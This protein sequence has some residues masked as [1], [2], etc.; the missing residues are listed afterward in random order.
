MK[1]LFRAAAGPRIGFGHVVRCRSLARA[2][3][4][5][6]RVWLRGTAQTQAHAQRAGVDVV[7]GRPLDTDAW[8]READVI[9]LDE[10]SGAHARRCLA[11]ARRFAVP[12]V[13][14]HDLG[15]ARVESDLVVDGSI[16]AAEAATA[17]QRALMGPKYAVLDPSILE[18]RARR[19]Q[20]AERG[21]VLIALGG[22]QHVLSVGA[23]LA[24]AILRRRPEVRVRVACGF[25][26]WRQLLSV[27]GV[28]WMT[29]YGGLGE[30]L[31]RA[32]VAVVAGG[33]TLY[34]ACAIGVPVVALAL[35]P[36]QALTTRRFAS[37]RAAVDAGMCSRVTDERAARAVARLLDDARARQRLTRAGVALVD[38]RGA[39]RVAAAV[40]RL[41]VVTDG[42]RHVA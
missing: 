16:W 8:R 9:V 24:A 25:A 4:V 22:G 41:T 40:R 15:L 38:G 14:I 36:H 1:V 27:P 12:V 31:A 30:E 7:D 19:D 17:P 11:E 2:L 6:P 37:A 33:V 23:R 18:W 29:A 3:G 13:S 28:E 5:R 42:R 26:R 39:L 32:S 34:E 10:P 21:R 20:Q 35:T